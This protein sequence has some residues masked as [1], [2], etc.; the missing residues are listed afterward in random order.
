MLDLNHL[1]HK[2]S[3]TFALAIPLLPEPTVQ[4]VTIAYLLFRIADT[5]EDAAVWSREQRLTAL[6]QF[7]Q[8]LESKSLSEAQEL[9]KQWVSDNPTT[10][11]GYLELL[12]QTPLVLQQWLALAPDAIEI[13]K[14]HT[15]RTTLGM[16]KFIEQSNQA[17]LL[18]LQELSDLREYC[19]AVAGI[20]GEMLTELFLLN[21]TSLT[22][23]APYLR[24][25]G[26]LFGE[27]LQLTNILKDSAV[28][29]S[30][31]RSFL[32]A[33]IKRSNVFT[34]AYQD[35]ATA[36]DY[37]IALQKAGAPRGVVAFCALPLLLAQ[38]TLKQVEVHG[39]GA[40]LTRS[41]LFTIVQ[42]MNHALDH[43][44][45]VVRKYIK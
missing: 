19:Y 30:E 4:E 37:T 26:Y 34:L 31:G 16:A 7:W 3:R 20:V 15:Q 2:T 41:E 25:R 18:H 22:Q 23:I 27:A 8:L 9:A 42:R 40:K 43:N 44:Q 29:I 33:N 32:P 13:V 10:H 28:D 5:F 36:V 14:K 1:L 21:R 45:P 17:G 38:P 12:A 24:E 39:P 6:H 35:L 11:K